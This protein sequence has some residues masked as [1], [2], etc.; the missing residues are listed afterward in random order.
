MAN[1]TKT[2]EWITNILTLGVAIVVLVIVGKHFIGSGSEARSGNSALRI[3]SEVTALSGTDWK[4]NDST[5]VIALQVGCH[6]C[7]AS[8]PFYSDLIRS[9][10]N[11]SVHFVA[12]LPQPVGE[13]QSFLHSLH[14]NVPDIRQFDLAKL[15]VDATPTLILVDQSGH[16]R[17]TWTGK[18]TS[19]VEDQVFRKVG[20]KRPPALPAVTRNEEPPQPKSNADFITAKDLAILLKKDPN[21]PI[22]DIRSRSDFSESHVLN[23]LNI[24]ND[25]LQSRAEREVP[26]SSTVVFYCS[27]DSNCETSNKAKGIQTFCAQSESML[28]GLGF[29]HPRMLSDQMYNIEAAGV[30]TFQ[31]A[32]DG[33]TSTLK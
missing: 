19:E 4:T 3:G 13:A 21:L 5:L 8:A 7:E 23:S 15:G 29:L 33:L 17:E 14:L 28:R 25:E 6:W 31:H 12:V 9:A 27:F 24:P 22:I 20:L 1:F 2:F 26:L 10:A 11:N 18:L 32:A 30:A 16:I